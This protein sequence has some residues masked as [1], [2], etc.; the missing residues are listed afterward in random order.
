MLTKV[1]K[2]TF[3]F[4]CY[5]LM[6]LIT[7]YSRTLHELTDPKGFIFSMNHITFPNNIAL[8]F[9]TKKADLLY[10]NC[11]ISPYLSIT[12]IY[13][14]FTLCNVYRYLLN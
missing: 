9:Q 12:F 5:L 1:A 6:M 8:E 13:M 11:E 2:C 10:L 14:S 3:T 4:P 7:C